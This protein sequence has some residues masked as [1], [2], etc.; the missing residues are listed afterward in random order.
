MD[1][2]KRHCP[3]DQDEVSSYILLIKDAYPL[4][5]IWVLICFRYSSLIYTRKYLHEMKIL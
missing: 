2:Y 3:L 5:C 4:Q 1:P